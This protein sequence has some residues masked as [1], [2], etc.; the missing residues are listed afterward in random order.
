LVDP[1]FGAK[2]SGKIRNT[3]IGFMVTDDEAPGQLLSRNAP[4][5]GEGAK[6][7]MGRFDTTCIPNRTSAQLSPIASFSTATA[8]SAASTAC[9]M[10][11]TNR[12]IFTKLQYLFRY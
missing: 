11:R 10:M 12:A 8:A 3:S 2:L 5:Y 9:S 6:V 1:R 7:V 4:G